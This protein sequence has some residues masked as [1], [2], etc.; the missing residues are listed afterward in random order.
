[1]GLVREQTERQ[2]Y[3]LFHKHGFNLNYVKYG[4]D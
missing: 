4:G 3:K 2:M 1:M